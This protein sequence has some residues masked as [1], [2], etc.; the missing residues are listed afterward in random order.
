MRFV[1]NLYFPSI[2]PQNRIFVNTLLLGFGGKGGG[3]DIVFRGENGI[4]TAR[5]SPKFNKKKT[6]NR[7]SKSF[8]GVMEGGIFKGGKFN[9]VLLNL[10]FT[11]YFTLDFRREA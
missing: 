6:P 9:K 4:M 3:Q 8:L 10:M 5:L 7:F 2:I 1:P 11:I